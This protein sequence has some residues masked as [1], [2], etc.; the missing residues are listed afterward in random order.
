MNTSFVRS[1]SK[2]ESKVLEGKKRKNKLVDSQTVFALFHDSI[3]RCVYLNSVADV[4]DALCQL[5]QCRVVKLRRPLFVG[6]HSFSVDR[7]AGRAAIGSGSVRCSEGAS[8]LT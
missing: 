4:T 2:V 6:S 5:A 8:L 3:E 1:S 7:E